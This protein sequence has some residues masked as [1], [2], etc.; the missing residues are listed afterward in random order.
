MAYISLK[1]LSNVA[2]EQN[3][4]IRY[5]QGAKRRSFTVWKENRFDVLKCAIKIIISI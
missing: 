2:Q 1:N 5:N 3:T 4:V